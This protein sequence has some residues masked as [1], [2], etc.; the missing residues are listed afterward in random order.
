MKAVIMSAVG[1]PEVLRVADV[2]TPTAGANQILVR[3]HAAGVNP[4]DY[5]LRQ[6]GAL[7]FGAGKVLGFDAAGVVEAVGAGVTDFAAGDKVFYSPDFSLPGA[8][9]QFN[10][11]RAELVAHMPARLSFEQAAAIPLAGMT[12]WDGLFTRGGLTLGQTA[13]ITAANGGVGSIAVQLAKAA[14]AQVL[15]TCSTR[16][17]EFVYSL[18]TACGK[19]PD[20]LLNYQTENW[21]EIIK[22]EY[23]HGLDVVFDCAGGDVVSRCIPLM[24]ALGRIVTIV[25][26]TGKLDEGYRKNVAIHYEFLQRR[27]GTLELLKALLERGQIVPLVDSV[28][29]L[30]EAAE[31]HR[32]LEA[33]GV[34]GKIILQVT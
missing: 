24:K 21:S 32:R 2:A 14:G 6:T 33:G 7:G 23:T 5:K 28:M 15:A 17:A 30:E 4:I 31:A 25:N 20:R 13:L 8:Y 27:R 9:A 3:V 22:S 16:S 29:P 19:G 34:R 10:V 1:G 18:P 12:A 26:P 11:V